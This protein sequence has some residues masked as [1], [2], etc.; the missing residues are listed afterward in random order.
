[1]AIVSCSKPFY[2]PDATA[3]SV[4]VVVVVFVGQVSIEQ[5]GGGEH[6]GDGHEGR[7]AAGCGEVRSTVVCD[8]GALVLPAYGERVGAYICYKRMPSMCLLLMIAN[9]R[10]DEGLSANHGALRT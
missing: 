6:G 9:D 4:I 3:P 1:M 10:R 7:E 8:C 2:A 5:G